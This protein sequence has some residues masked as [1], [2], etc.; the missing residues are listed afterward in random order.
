MKNLRIG[1]LYKFIVKKS[2]SLKWIEMLGIASFFFILLLSFLFLIRRSQDITITVRLLNTN[3]PPALYN[4]PRQLL[5]ENIK[6][7]LKQKGELGTTVA[8]VIDVYKYPSNDVNQDTFVTLK[9]NSVY[10]RLTGQYSFDNLPLLLGDYRT[11]QLQDVAFSGVIVDINTTGIP[12]QQKRFL[13]TGILDPINNNDLTT[14]QQMI[15]FNGVSA[16][17]IRNYLADQVQPGLKITDTNG[18][19]AAEIASVEK[20]PGKI[21]LVQNGSYI[22]VNDPNST[23]VELTLNLIADKVGDGY[24]F[25]KE[26]SLNV[27]SNIFLSF[28]NVKLLLTI[29]SITQAN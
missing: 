17:G 4:F 29:T 16:D 1:K 22:S 2:L 15:P 18:Q 25:Q 5:T 12:R 9:I 14:N 6:K 19:V 21:N 10:N 20:T 3:S 8:E 7:G 13:V 23:R 26:Q 28:S 24:F 11:F 27:G